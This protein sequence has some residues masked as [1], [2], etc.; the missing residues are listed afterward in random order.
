[1]LVQGSQ[2]RNAL[3]GLV[4][5]PPEGVADLVDEMD[6]D[7]QVKL[8]DLTL[9]SGVKQVKVTF[10]CEEGDERA[11]AVK[12]HAEKLYYRKLS[13]M[14]KF[15]KYGRV[16]FERAW[17]YAAGVNTCDLNE[18]PYRQTKMILEGGQFSGI[19]LKGKD[20]Q[21]NPVTVNLQ[22]AYAFW[23]GLDTTPTEP[24]GRSRYIGAPCD[25]WHERRNT[26]RLLRIFLDKFALGS[27]I[28]YA[29]TEIPDPTNNDPNAPKINIASLI[30][31]QF[32]AYEAGGTVV[33][34]NERQ[35]VSGGPNGQQD[36]GYKI[37]VV[38]DNA[39]PQD[40]APILAVMS[41]QDSWQLLAFGIP[42]KTVTEGSEQ[43]SF[44]MVAQQRIVLLA[45][46]EE[47]FLQLREQFQAGV[48]D[49]MVQMNG[50]S[51]VTMD[52]TPITERPD[53]LAS[54]IV[55]AWLTSPKLSEVVAS[56][57][58]DIIAM[59]EACGVPVTKEG[60]ER[61]TK[62]IT[63]LSNPPAQPTN[64]DG[65]VK[66]PEQLKYEYAVKT[67]EDPEE[68]PPKPPVQLAAPIVCS[69]WPSGGAA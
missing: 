48:I 34:D 1:M 25:M 64:P 59:L 60:H 21:K 40:S 12:D 4:Q 16:A 55:K 2:T 65:T 31:Q 50:C 47:V 27:R 14:L 52:Y 10:N 7:Y 18:L 24:H 22:R 37:Q 49:A 46:F 11:T 43:G 68:T 28:I 42:P 66:T 57:T 61:L 29:P 36:V 38:D 67:G 45:V 35:L 15:L 3:A 26:R 20:E 62:L 9:T 8:S 63:R 44:A 58:V 33:I 30:H 17:N 51:P 53:D 6:K 56:G 41:E 39:K 54:E 19:E 13:A 69:L 23:L 32:A 5:K